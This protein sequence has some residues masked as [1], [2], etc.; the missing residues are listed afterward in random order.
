[1]PLTQIYAEI[2]N[3]MRMQ[4]E[5]GYHPPDSRANKYHKIDLRTT[6]KGL[7]VQAREG[8]FTPK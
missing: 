2:A 8:Y 4:Y 1:M 6:D 7:I 3:D 5:I